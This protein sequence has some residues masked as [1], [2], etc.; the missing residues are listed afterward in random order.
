MKPSACPRIPQL[1]SRAPGPFAAKA[2][3]DYHSAFY[4]LFSIQAP[5]PFDGDVWLPLMSFVM[6]V[7]RSMMNVGFRHRN[8]IRAHLRGFYGPP[9]FFREVTFE[10]YSVVLIEKRDKTIDAVLGPV[11]KTATVILS[12]LHPKLLGTSGAEE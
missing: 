6:F 10:V 8:T 3:P 1:W 12:R 9:A 7:R 4:C 2:T 5:L 11:I